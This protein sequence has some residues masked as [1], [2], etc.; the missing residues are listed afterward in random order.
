MWPQSPAARCWVEPLAGGSSLGRVGGAAVFAA[1]RRDRT[2]GGRRGLALGATDV[3]RDR[4]LEGGRGLWP[5]GLT[6]GWT[7]GQT[8]GGG[9]KCG[10][11][12]Q[13]RW[14]ALTRSEDIRL[15][16][17]P[18]LPNLMVSFYIKTHNDSVEWLLSPHSAAT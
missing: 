6:A 10:A 15:G 9:W 8:A 11:S 14:A 4:G 1:E 12:A 13:S 7:A 18:C 5:E 3:G 16:P 17:M 2:E